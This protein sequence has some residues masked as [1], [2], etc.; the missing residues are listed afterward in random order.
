MFAIRPKLLRPETVDLA[1]AAAAVVVRETIL[2]V[3]D[4]PI[5]RRLFAQA[6]TGAGYRVHEAR[7]GAEA[8]KVFD[9][10][11]DTIDL[12]LTDMRMPFMGGRE[13]AEQL[14][15]RRATLKL[16]C[17]S[18][19]TAIEDGAGIDFLA[20]PFSRHA[21]LDKIRQVLDRR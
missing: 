14:R 19:H 15:A 16:I 12:L 2:L 20:K 5:V 10:H 4:E 21:L 1:S 6:L 11:G 7:N 18:G 17:I 13:L 3:E 8:V 9:Q